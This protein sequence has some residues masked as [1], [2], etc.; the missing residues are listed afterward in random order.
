MDWKKWISFN[1]FVNI[2][3]PPLCVCCTNRLIESEKHICLN[4]LFNLPLSIH[5]SGINSLEGKLS[6]IFP[7]VKANFWGHYESDNNIQSI[8]HNIKYKK[9]KTL[10]VYVGQ[11]ATNHL[12]PTAFFEEIDFLVPVP[13]HPKRLKTRT[14]NQS[15][16][17]CE[18]IS[19][20]TSIPLITT[21]FKRIINN[22]SQ[23][24][25]SKTKRIENVKNIFSFDSSL[26]HLKNKHILIV[27]DVIT[28]GVTLSALIE[29]IPK[30]FNIK[31]SIFCVGNT[32]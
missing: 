21:A 9:N 16:K 29:V 6:G 27:D 25:F 32:R 19:I 5:T 11:I 7:F 3:F 2:F 17:I 12:K 10:G 14:F 8:I 23:T 20:I 31:V 15:E 30:E 1:D 4:C 24:K 22:R 26:Y 18:G 13:L 28:S